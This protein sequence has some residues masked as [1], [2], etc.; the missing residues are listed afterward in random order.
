M[1]LRATG[2]PVFVRLKGSGLKDAW[3]DADTRLPAQ[4]RA[5]LQSARGTW[6]PLARRLRQQRLQPLTTHLAAPGTL[7]AIKHLLVLP[8]VALVGVPVEVF[9]DGTTVSYALSG[10]FYAHLRKQQKP[11]TKSLLALGNPIFDVPPLP[12]SRCPPAACC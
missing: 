1:L 6:Q 5:A 9:A 11:G 8:S 7:P 10:T 3:T 4:L 12:T 2:A